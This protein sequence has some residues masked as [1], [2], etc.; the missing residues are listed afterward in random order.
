MFTL[1]RV[2]LFIASAYG[3]AITVERVVAAANAVIDL[4]KRLRALFSKNSQLALA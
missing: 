1:I 3:F 2:A 4:A